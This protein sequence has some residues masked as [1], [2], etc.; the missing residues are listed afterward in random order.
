MAKGKRNK[1]RPEEIKKKIIIFCIF[2]EPTLCF[3][4]ISPFAQTRIKTHYF[5]RARVTK[6]LTKTLVKKQYGAEYRISMNSIYP[7]IE[8]H[9]GSNKYLNFYGNYGCIR[10]FYSTFRDNRPSSSPLKFK[11]LYIF[12][13][14]ASDF[15]FRFSLKTF[16]L[17]KHVYAFG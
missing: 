9:D 3:F 8:C 6:I 2:M 15:L 12:K 1:L 14:L 13:R 10:S 11:L 5:I 17:R 7:E 16:S 4:L